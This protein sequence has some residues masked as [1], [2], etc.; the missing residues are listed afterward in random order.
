MTSVELGTATQ[1]TG[2]MFT[3]LVNG[4]KAVVDAGFDFTG[5]AA[6]PRLRPT[7]VLHRHHG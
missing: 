7:L 3:D 6:D 5:F 4:E 1:A 2:G